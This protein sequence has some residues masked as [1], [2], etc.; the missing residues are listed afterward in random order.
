MRD[1]SFGQLPKQDLTKPHPG[2]LTAHAK[3]APIK[4]Q[5][6]G[7]K[8]RW[9]ASPDR[10]PYVVLSSSTTNSYTNHRHHTGQGSVCS[11]LILG[12]SHRP[13]DIPFEPQDVPSHSFFVLRRGSW[14]AERLRGTG[15]STSGTSSGRSAKLPL[16]P[17]FSRAVTRPAVKESF[18]KHMRVVPQMPLKEGPQGVHFL[19][20]F[21]THVF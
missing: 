5:Q 12:L 10:S 11:L 7:Q 16:T 19:I 1:D 14:M 21:W 3:A 17:T 4:Q 15:F 20:Q 2:D 13:P 18:P 9:H 6:G 8:L